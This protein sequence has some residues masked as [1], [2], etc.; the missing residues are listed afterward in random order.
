M[1]THKSNEL[2]LQFNESNNILGSYKN[3]LQNNKII[4]N[5]FVKYNNDYTNFIFMHSVLWS[6][7]GINKINNY[8][9]S[10]IEFQIDA[11]L[12]FLGKEKKI[13][14]LRKILIRQV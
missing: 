8:F 11:Y 4:L 10:I 9:Q 5:D 1:S 12:S 7:N 3:N 2:D 13:K 14:Q 6:Y